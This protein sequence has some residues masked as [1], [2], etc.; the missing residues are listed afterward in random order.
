MAGFKSKKIFCMG[1]SKL[2][3]KPCQAKG[4]PT[5]SFNKHG[6]QI[7]KCRYHGGQNTSFFGF[8]DRANRGGYNK[9]GYS[10]DAKIKSLAKLKQ[11]KDK[12]L[13]YVRQYY[14]NRI[15]ERTNSL[16]RY[17]SEYS[18]R[19]FKRRKNSSKYK[20]GRNLTDNLD[21]VLSILESRSKQRS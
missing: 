15:K 18:I 11:F 9:L 3:G 17:S 8:R 6:I 19:A 21:Q 2:S 14:Q 10:D 5:N 1:I 13:E 7:Y 12:D 16:G 4:Y 20:E